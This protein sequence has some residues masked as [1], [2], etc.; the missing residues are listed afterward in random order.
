M[1][2]FIVKLTVREDE[3]FFSEEFFLDFSKHANTRLTQRL[4]E[5]FTS[6]WE[7][8]NRI[9]FL[10]EEVPEYLLNDIMIGETFVIFDQYYQTSYA[11][12]VQT[13]S[14]DVLTVF[15]EEERRSMKLYEGEKFLVFGSN[16]VFF[17]I[18]KDR[19]KTQFK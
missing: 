8:L 13:N 5:I 11:I 14:F 10:L 3:E 7:V 4:Y 1:R 9:K 17:G 6:K 16:E 15:D 2:D 19:K 18:F 12:A